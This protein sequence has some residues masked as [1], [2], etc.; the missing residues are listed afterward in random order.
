MYIVSKRME[1]AGAHRLELNYESACTRLHGHNWIITCYFASEELNEN[2][3]VVDFKHVKNAIHGKLD[4]RHVNEV[5]LD[6]NPTAENIAKWCVD[7]FP[8]CYKV[9]AQE[10]EG[11][12]AIYVDDN[13]VE[14]LGS[15][16]VVE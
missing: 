8:N 12:M 15:V 4:H 1:V 6:V 10:S 11:N 2:G 16:V 14:K 9:I 5:I 13:Y 7:Q 3:M